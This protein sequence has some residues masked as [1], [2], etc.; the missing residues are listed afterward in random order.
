MDASRLILGHYDDNTT[1]RRYLAKPVLK[2]IIGAPD[3]MILKAPP[4]YH[5]LRRSAAI[6]RH[7]SARAR[8]DASLENMPAPCRLL[9][10]ADDKYFGIQQ[11][12]L[13]DAYIYFS[14]MNAY[15]AATG[16]AT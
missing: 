5:F 4:A 6:S 9:P 13:F 1:F 14:L 2:N 10:P 11:K 3:M 16:N 15:I 7:A 12:M 8:Q